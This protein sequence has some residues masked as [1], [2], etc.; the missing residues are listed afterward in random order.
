[1]RIPQLL[2]IITRYANL[3][4]KCLVAKIFMMPRQGW[5]SLNAAIKVYD[6]SLSFLLI[7]YLHRFNELET[8]SGLFWSSDKDLN[9]VAEIFIF[10]A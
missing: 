5:G 9:M 3:K 10:I 2:A 7:N 8:G 4:Q 6:A 1:M